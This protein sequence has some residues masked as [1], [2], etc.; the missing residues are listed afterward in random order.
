MDDLVCRSATEAAELV[1]TA[2]AASLELT[3]A[4]EARAYSWRLARSRHARLAAFRVGSSPGGAAAWQRYFE[5]FDVFLCPANFTAAFAH[6]RRPF[7]QRTIATPEGERPCADQPFWVAHASLPG[8][9][10][11]AMPIGSTRLGLPVGAQVIGPLYE[12]DTAL[13]FAEML[14]EHVDGYQWPPL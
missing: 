6:D 2:Q 7:D 3:E 4:P 8:L 12:D 5:D 14:A 9:P 1:R 13:S 10:A 11:L